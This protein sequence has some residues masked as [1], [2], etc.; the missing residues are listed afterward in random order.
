MFTRN[1]TEVEV[2]L[3]I[4]LYYLIEYIIYLLLHVLLIST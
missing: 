4:Y 3:F 2:I 1:V